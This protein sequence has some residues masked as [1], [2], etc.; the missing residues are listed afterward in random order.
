MAFTVRN[1]KD[2]SKRGL[3]YLILKKGVK[4]KQKAIEYALKEVFE[5][6]IKNKTIQKL[7]FENNLLREKISILIKKR[8]SVEE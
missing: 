2:K 7:I 5:S 4:T 8:Y 1:L 6:D 3:E